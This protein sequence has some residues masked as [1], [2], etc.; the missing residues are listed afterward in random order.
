MHGVLY[1]L[2]SVLTDLLLCLHSGVQTAQPIEA[3]EWE[4]RCRRGSD[5][6]TL[7][8]LLTSRSCPF[9]VHNPSDH[10]RQPGSHTAARG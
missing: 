5:V 4:A 3:P 9:R 7:A 6:Y 1:R 10:V 2:L 8:N